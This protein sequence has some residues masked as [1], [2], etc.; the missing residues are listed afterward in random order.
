MV[1]LFIV[2]HIMHFTLGVGGTPFEDLKPYENVVAGF[3]VI[4][5]GIAYVVCVALLGLHLYHGLWS[6]FQTLGLAHPRYTPKLKLFATLFT[7]V[8]VLGFISVPIA[9]MARIVS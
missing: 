5:I 6:M 1:A 4:P 9:V 8:V 7:L 3:Q 2:Y